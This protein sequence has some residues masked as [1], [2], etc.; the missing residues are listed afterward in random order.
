[1]PPKP[2]WANTDMLADRI[3]NRTTSDMGHDFGPEASAR[4]VLAEKAAQLRET[5][6]KVVLNDGHFSDEYCEDRIGKY[7]RNRS[8]LEQLLRI[9]VIEQKSEEWHRVRQS[10]ITASDFAQA[11]GEG[12]FGTQLDF[13]KKKCGYEVIDFDANC[14]PL[15][16]GI[17]FEDVACAIYERRN[18]CKVLPFGLIRHPTIEH[19]GASPDGITGLGVMLEIKCPYRRKIDNEVP[20][21]YFF[22]IQGQLEVCGLDECDY[23]ECEFRTVMDVEELKDMCTRNEIGA[24]F[25]DKDSDDYGPGRYDYSPIFVNDNEGYAE[26]LAWI[27]AAKKRHELDNVHVHLWYLDVVSVIRV[28]RD[29]AFIDQKL[30]ELADVWSQVVAYRKDRKLYDVEIPEKGK[31]ALLTSCVAAGAAKK[32]AASKSK[33]PA[34]GSFIGYM[35]L[36]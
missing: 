6:S 15:K 36:D 10:I 27:E 33:A 29:Q 28:Y 32:G 21:Q 19:F 23:L 9:P 34:G 1:M 26:L 14:P 4:G 22:Q 3:V 7:V 8:V 20:R 16:W 25:E 2:E 24:I 11:L 30:A 12:K 5:L 35:F 17:M 18:G 13:F 31:Q